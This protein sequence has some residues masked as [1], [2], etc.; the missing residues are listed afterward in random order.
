MLLHMDQAHKSQPSKLFMLH[1]ICIPESFLCAH[2][3]EY[4][5]LRPCKNLLTQNSDKVPI[6]IILQCYLAEKSPK[7][8]IIKKLHWT[9]FVLMVITPSTTD[10][11]MWHKSWT[12]NN[13]TYIISKNV[14]N[15][16]PYNIPQCLWK[17]S[18]PRSFRR[19]SIDCLKG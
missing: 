15:V 5:H 10:Y 19:D 13:I 7:K 9:H 2:Y 16:K 3:I 6:Y 4:E 1:I 12:V 17:Y 8:F 11:K 18:L 14:N